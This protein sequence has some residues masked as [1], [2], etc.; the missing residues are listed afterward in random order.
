[1]SPIID[2]ILQSDLY[3]FTMQQCVFHQYP[4]ANVRYAF[5]CRNEGIKLGFLA[6][7]VKEQINLMRDLRLT[8]PE[9]A[10]L[11]KLS[12]MTDDYI[13]FLRGYKFDPETE[14]G[15]KDWQGDLYIDIFGPWH[16][17][18]LWEVPILAI[19]NQLYFSNIT[20][21]EDEGRGRLFE[22]IELIQQ[23]PRFTF[24]DFGTRRRFSADWQKNVLMI[25]KN[26]CPNNLIGTSNVKLAMDLNIKPIG[27]MAHE[28]ISA[29]LALTDNIKESQKRAFYVWLQEYGTNLGIALTD[30]FTTKAF[31]KDFDYTLANNF[32]GVRQ[33]S[34]DPIEFG[35][36]MIEHYKKL[37]IDPRTKSI[38]F[39]D[40]LDFK[41]A[42]QI[43]KEFTGLIGI[44]FGI[45]TSL[46]NDIGRNPINIVVKLVECNREP[47]VKISDNMTKA[48]GERRTV[49]LVKKAYGLNG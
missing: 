49:D 3:K 12:F 15:V 19:V 18:I 22:K 33:D 4:E 45:G 37:G 26:R 36:A 14:V 2:S 31:F 28:W 24:A 20:D 41:K 43:Y 16:R 10:Y 44:S 5:K 42:I 1:M 38:V 48:I 47:V 32:S 35:K 8:D 46:M 25:L 30:T 21:Y 29:H 39:S 13:D 7:Q 34:G 40:G 11:K 23:Y 9:A 17:T 27:T 6:P